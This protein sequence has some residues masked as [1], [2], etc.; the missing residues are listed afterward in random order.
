MN[1]ETKQ[2]ANTFEPFVL[3]DGKIRWLYGDEDIMEDLGAEISECYPDNKTI[4]NLL[5]G[6]SNEF[7]ELQDENAELKAENKLLNKALDDA[8]LEQDL[9]WSAKAAYEQGVTLKEYLLKCARY[10]LDEEL[11]GGADVK[12]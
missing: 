9:Y 5:N 4:C 12:D 2:K 7:V 10:E 11:K 8:C 6:Y 3:E 1:E